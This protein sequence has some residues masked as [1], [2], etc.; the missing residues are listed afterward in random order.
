MVR[1]MAVSRCAQKTY[2]V[3]PSFG[4]PGAAPVENLST[5]RAPAANSRRDGYLEKKGERGVEREAAWPRAGISWRKREEDRP[6]GVVRMVVAEAES[7][8]DR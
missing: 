7:L 4:A 2:G 5:S 3:I 1:R 6:D 8:S